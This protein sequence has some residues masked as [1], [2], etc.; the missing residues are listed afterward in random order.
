MLKEN[1]E[2]LDDFRSQDSRDSESI[3][4]AA[5]L[6]PEVE[7]SSSSGSDLDMDD[8]DDDDDDDDND[9][10]DNNVKNNSWDSGNEVKLV[11][12]FRSCHKDVTPGC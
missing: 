9:S 1:V 2:D 10:E 3:V 11:V 8:D 4:G 6:V 5:A 7:T 12:W